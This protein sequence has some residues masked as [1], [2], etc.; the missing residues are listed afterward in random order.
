MTYEAIL[1]VLAYASSHECAVLIVAT[2]GT[3]V[4]GVPTSVD[5]HV[6]AHEVYLHPVDDADAEIGV[7]LAAIVRVELV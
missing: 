5:T 3:E 1:E 7:S 4:V 6:T 2:D